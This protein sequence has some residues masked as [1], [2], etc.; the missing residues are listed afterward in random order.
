MAILRHT[1]PDGSM[2]H[3]LLLAPGEVPDDDRAVPTWRCPADPLALAPDEGMAIEA[4]PPHR[5]LYLRLQ[6]T[7]QLDAGRG[8]VDPVHRGW[9]FERAGLLW[10]ATATAP[11][12]AFTL[13]SG[14]LRRSAE[15]IT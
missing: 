11:A 10:M 7:R 15:P 9:H 14:T 3:D 5:G 6:A 4:L 13:V 2:H 8:R 12:R 1:L